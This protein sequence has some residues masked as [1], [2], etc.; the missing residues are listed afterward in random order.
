[1]ILASKSVFALSANRIFF[2]C[3]FQLAVVILVFDSCIALAAS[4]GD[5][6]PDAMA[7][8]G[9]RQPVVYPLDLALAQRWNRSNATANMP[10][11]LPNLL[12]QMT[13]WGWCSSQ[14]ENEVW[15]GNHVDASMFGNFRDMDGSAA[16]NP[17]L[18]GYIYT[19]LW[20]TLDDSTRDPYNLGDKWQQD[21][22]S[23]AAARGFDEEEFYLHTAVPIANCASPSRTRACRLNT[24]AGSWGTNWYGNLGNPHFIEYTRDRIRRLA[25][26]DGHKSIF[27]DIMGS[28]GPRSLACSDKLPSIEYGTA[29]DI[30]EK[31]LIQLVVQV[32]DALGGRPIQVN[33]ASYTSAV[34]P[35]NGWIAIAAGSVQTEG[36]NTPFFE[37]NDAWEH[38]DQLLEAGV[39]VAFNFNSY[40]REDEL[41]AL[42]KW[43]H[44]KTRYSEGNYQNG[45]SRYQMTTLAQHYLLTPS[46]LSD[47]F[48]WNPNP[49]DWSVPYAKHW[50][51]AV[52]VDLGAPVDLRRVLLT[53]GYDGA[54]QS[55]D[56]YRREFS[57]AYVY[58]RP[59]KKWSNGAWDD[60][61]AIEVQLLEKNLR[62][63]GPDGLSSPILGNTIRLRNGEGVILLRSPESSAKVKT[64][65]PGM[66]AIVADR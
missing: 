14:K 22:A 28:D 2:R 23:W 54:G 51:P 58:A 33:T 8:A 29:R 61:T 39:K 34:S 7:D 9:P 27:L 16:V 26:A 18:A 17:Q 35:F 55:Y 24:R 63:L 43:G 47:N 36:L 48:Y 46:R 10:H 25:G 20:Y 40:T 66:P 56:L 19:L 12:V 45:L 37:Y 38:I 30:Y 15:L 3:L 62:R 59:Q 60:S 13:C 52:E 41:V 4:S 50:I 64:E 53:S 1:M 32:R 44:W 11:H 5:K 65:V 42:G 49:Q 6:K 57:N 21:L 31:D